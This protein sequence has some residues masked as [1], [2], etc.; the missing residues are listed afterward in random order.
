MIDDFEGSR[1]E[2]MELLAAQDELPAYILRAQRVEEVWESLVRRCEQ[3]KRK[4]LELPRIRLAQVAA[5][6]DRKW[7]LLPDQRQLR[8]SAVQRLLSR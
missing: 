7:E 1:T 6:V 2:F 4:L 8:A 5:L 3:E